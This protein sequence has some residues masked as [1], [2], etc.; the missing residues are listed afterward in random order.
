MEYIQSNSEKMLLA[1]LKS[2]YGNG[3]NLNVLI[4]EHPSLS[5]PVNITNLLI[6]LETTTNYDYITIY[7][8]QD[9]KLWF[10]WK[11]SANVATQLKEILLEHASSYEYQE[12][13][14]IYNSNIHYDIIFKE[15]TKQIREQESTQQKEKQLFETYFPNSQISIDKLQEEAYHKAL[16]KRENRSKPIALIIE[17][18]KFS[19][20]LLMTIIQNDFICILASSAIEAMTLYLQHAPNLALIDIDLPDGNGHEVARFISKIDPNANMVMVSGNNY[21]KDVKKAKANGV[22]GYIIKPYSREKIKQT[23][24]QIKL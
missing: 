8:F 24:Q 21:M 2:A 11:G 1:D 12:N 10:V 13:I 22:K 7:E 17:D 15:V 3:K 20:K 18:Q 6:K 5:Q 4:Y 9:K 19:S 23:I 16:Q 14:N